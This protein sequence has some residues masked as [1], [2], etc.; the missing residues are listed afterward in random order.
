MRFIKLLPPLAFLIACFLGGLYG[1]PL[2][3]IVYAKVFPTP[4]FITGDYSDIYAK[5]GQ[6]VVLYS[7]STCPYCKKVRALFAKEGISYT[8][9]VV[10]KSNAATASFI[11][12]GGG[13]VPMIFIGN[14]KIVG[15]NEASIQSAIDLLSRKGAPAKAAI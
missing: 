9:Y 10:D 3:K 7:T 13:A 5:A 1:G 14:R 4:A 12:L 6:P 8:D 11:K 2:A 15:F